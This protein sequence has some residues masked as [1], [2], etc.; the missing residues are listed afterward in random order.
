[1]KSKAVQGKKKNLSWPRP[2]I[3]VLGYLVVISLVLLLLASTRDPSPW[4][5][6]LTAPILLAAFQYRRWVYL[7]MAAFFIVETNTAF[8]ILQFTGLL[9]VLQVIWVTTLTITGL[10][11][12]TYRYV[13]AQK[14]LSMT[15][16]TS[17]QSYR[18]L[19]LLADRQNREL[20]LLDDVQ[21]A[22]AQES[23]PR[24]I[25]RAVVE[26][27]IQTFGYPR[28]SIYSYDG[29]DLVLQYQV[30]YTNLAP[31]ASSLHGIIGRVARTGQPILL[32]NEI[33]KSEGLPVGQ[34]SFSRVSVPLLDQQDVIGVLNVEG[35]PETVLDDTDLR[36]LKAISLQAVIAIN[37]ARLHF[38]IRESEE[39]FQS[40]VNNL[41][42]G[43]ATIDE[44]DTFIFAN[45]AAE[46]I[47]GV[48][49]GMLIGRD[50][51]EFSPA[52]KIPHLLEP[53]Y[54][55][56]AGKT[57]IYELEIDRVDG[58]RRNLLV[59]ST[60]QVD[61]S[62][63]VSGTLAVFH[64]F[65]DRKKMEVELRYLSTHDTLTGL[66]NRAYIETE[67]ARLES[68]R[69]YPISIFMIDVDG[70]KLINDHY[71]HSAGDD[72]LRRTATVLKASFRSEDVVARFGGDEFTVLLPGAAQPVA[73]AVCDRLHSNLT[74]Y[75]EDADE[76][77]LSLSIGVGTGA[78]GIP[79]SDVLKSADHQ[80]YE[81]KLNRHNSD[82]E[83]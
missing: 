60:P 34:N 10:A 69:H 6:V 76:I 59:T 4:G 25:F 63:N 56:V 19:A 3:F 80:M 9:P 18:T 1:M 66:Y 24:K 12:I 21:T 22:L 45:P 51:G 57:G 13:I 41:G 71:G 67:I 54:P 75:N 79:L 81:E 30:G 35:S 39:R 47:F 68:G 5:L 36:T 74:A 48:P 72:L 58:E 62:G 64:D 2:V 49:H 8:L 65:T 46:S 42:E 33:D 20:S 15:L 27:I 31:K 11:E 37:R 28:A 52:R 73:Q 17:E 26:S 40:L 14:Q 83:L 55:Q 29:K 70:M 43:V 61:E 77:R 7:S 38:Q 53:N 82:Q 44:K 78:A 50:I 16:Q 32:K 23:D